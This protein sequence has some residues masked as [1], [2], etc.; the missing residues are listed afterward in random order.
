M[1]GEDRGMADRLTPAQSS[2]LV[3][4]YRATFTADNHGDALKAMYSKFEVAFGVPRNVL[5]AEVMADRQAHAKLYR[6]LRSELTRRASRRK[7]TDSHKP[8]S[9]SN[10]TPAKKRANEAQA[11]QVFHPRPIRCPECNRKLAH[12]AVHHYGKRGRPCGGT[13]ATDARSLARKPTPMVE[14][15]AKWNIEPE[16]QYQRPQAQ[17]VH[18]LIVNL[19]T[20]K[21]QTTGVLGAIGYHVGRNGLDKRTRR[22]ILTEA[23]EVRLVAASPEFV[24]YVKGWGAPKSRQRLFKIRDSITAFAQIR[25][26]TKADYS[27]ALADWNSDL[28]WLKAKYQ[29]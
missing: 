17:R 9:K 23:V 3:I 16:P 11:S 22:A 7:S 1:A 12:A 28:A 8:P 29:V 18:K 21:W 14:T 13:S 4:A 27:A 24:D 6:K 5:H 26:S 15:L 10:Q 25:R 2:Q 20:G 19:D